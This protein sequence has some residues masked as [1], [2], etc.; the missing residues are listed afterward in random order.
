MNKFYSILLYLALTATLSAEV[1]FE[2]RVDNLQTAFEDPV[3]LELMVRVTDPAVTTEPLVPRQLP[4]FT[5]G[6]SGSSVTREGDT[7]IRK[8]TYDLKPI[9]SGTLTVPKLQLVYADS[10]AT[11]TLE[12]LPIQIAVA[13]PLPPP[14]TTDLPTW[15]IV[16]CVIFVL[17]VGFWW[18][19]RSRNAGSSL[20]PDWRK[21]Y[22]QLL[23]EARTY[24]GRENFQEFSQVAVRLVIALLERKFDRKLGGHTT[25]ELV[26][27]LG[28]EG[29]SKEQLDHVSELL[30]YCD[31]VKY[32]TSDQ[33]PEAG[34]QALAQLEKTVEPLL[35]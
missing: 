9:R 2:A 31:T 29:M 12:S 18:F 27:L 1:S 7:I 13:E 25:A 11:D 32:A 14:T 30:R 6:G 3:R 28:R 34:R 35:S 21:E 15:V 26:N 8:F 4:G 16:I 19:W 33:D 5:I 22:R 23:D 20:A 24:V 10:L 17:G